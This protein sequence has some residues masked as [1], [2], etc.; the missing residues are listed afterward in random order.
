MLF[1]NDMN[2]VCCGLA[3]CS[4]KLAIAQHRPDSGPQMAR[5]GIPTLPPSNDTT[6]RAHSGRNII[7]GIDKNK[8]SLM[9]RTYPIL[10]SEIKH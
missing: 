9:G 5:G 10:L 2:H 4:P 6:D 1:S 3:I 7:L 8:K